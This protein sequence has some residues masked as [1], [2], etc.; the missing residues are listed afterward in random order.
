MTDTV[1][2]LVVEIDLNDRDFRANIRGSTRDLKRFK[3]MITSSR[4][5][6]RQHERQVRG[7]AASFRHTVV[8]LGLLREALRTAWH[9]TGGL[10]AGV[11]KVN[12]EF[13][14]LNILLQGMSR[15]TTEIE[16]AKD[17]T[18][19]FNT[20]MNMAKTAPFTVKELTNSWVKFKSV[21]LDPADGS[22]RS[23]VDAVARFGGTDDILHRATIAVQQMAGK[24]VISMEEL[25]QQMG[26]AVP[27]SLVLLARGMN[28]SVRQ[29]VDAISKGQV[30]AKSA[31]A[32]LFA[33][34]ELTFGGASQKLME[35]FVGSLARLRTVW[36]LTLNEIGNSS[37]LFDTTK[38]YLKDLIEILQ[39]PAIRRFGID[40]AVAVREAMVWIVNA[41]KKMIEN[42]QDVKK[43]LRLVISAF[44]G[45]RL[46]VL[47]AARETG[48]LITAM[49]G[50]AVYM[51]GVP[52]LLGSI[53]TSVG[54]LVVG[55][56]KLA[57]AV[58][59]VAAA[60][61]LLQ[62]TN[63]VG[64]ITLV[65][66]A[67]IWWKTG[68]DDV[69]ESI[70][71]GIDALER[72]GVAADKN[73]ID[74]AKTELKAIQDQIK[75][76][77]DARVRVIV[78]ANK[79]NNLNDP[80]VQKGLADITAQMTVL[81]AE[82]QRVE[83]LIERVTVG[84][85]NEEAE[86]ARVAATNAF[87]AKMSEALNEARARDQEISE[88]FGNGDNADFTAEDRLKAR[89]ENW[90]NYQ[91]AIREEM[92]SQM[93]KLAEDLK[94]AENVLASEAIQGDDRKIWEGKRDIALQAIREIGQVGYKEWERVNKQ[95][96]EIA[97]DNVIMS[98]DEKELAKKS[99]ALKTFFESAS[100]KLA[101]ITAQLE[102]G[103]TES[104]KFKALW[105]SGR[106]GEGEVTWPE[107]IEEQLRLVLEVVGL[108]DAAT[109]DLKNKKAF[110]SAMKQ[111][112]G[113]IAQTKEE[114]LMYREALEGDQTDVATNKV[115]KFRRMLERL[116]ATLIEG[117]PEMEKFDAAAEELLKDV[118]NINVDEELLSVKNEMNQL[119]LDS[120]QNAR[121]RHAA[122]M[123]LLETQWEQLLLQNAEA[124]NV[125]LLKQKYEELRAK[126]ERAFKESTPI[127]RLAKEWEDSMGNMEEAGA[128][129]INGFVDMLVNGVAEGKFAFKDFAKSILMDIAKIIIRAQIAR[130]ILAA[131]G[132][133]GS[134][135]SST[136]LPG[137]SDSFGLVYS[138]LGNVVGP[139]GQM[140]LK[141]YARGGIATKPQISVFGEGDQ[142]E[143]Y[144]PLPDGRSI[145]VSFG[146][147]GQQPAHANVEVNVINESGT[148]VDAE[149]QGQAQFD[150][151][152][153][154]LDV[155]LRAAMRPGQFREGMQGAMK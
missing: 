84:I 80:A 145:P 72:Y 141:R 126:K 18:D 75:V 121:D 101:G 102:N 42:W 7:L 4:N 49:K 122:E 52:Y 154:V 151:E 32:K 5:P 85:Y 54:A 115:R 67:L 133:F 106:F 48:V 103:G 95:F 120:I 71:S 92:H 27:Q 23:L 107:D 15:G 58:K 128:R 66:G 33:E 123:A 116:R 55:K 99:A 146:R 109:E 81:G 137:N 147:G 46:A 61:K 3:D 53:A 44:V 79:N 69:N 119:D 29:M 124:D 89:Q 11:I 6:M 132:M 63:P 22:M 114:A 2:R 129:W 62:L 96:A 25:R 37:G 70:E 111:L 90:T 9:M 91:I 88:L 20:V 112:S 38:G 35:T 16:R 1:S 150:G 125:E 77:D 39:D 31:L 152:K 10:V 43:V 136:T 148:P 51:S 30:E 131:L 86:R 149:Q 50:F 14:R 47:L 100:A 142:N 140:P 144:V 118:Q 139:R 26:E 21:G 59:D 130:M 45:Y 65:V 117:T 76:L 93:L 78:N 127:G 24:G 57:K 143:A 74:R 8:S 138:A 60:F 13:E 105:E 97:R 41:G 135:T 108:V 40:M 98:G 83:A 134:G 87:K 34:F 113:Q 68:Q 19:Q 155:V 28:M 12:A 36:Q 94:A 110:E 17:A 64:W 56:V 153:Y 82:A 104:A 73:M